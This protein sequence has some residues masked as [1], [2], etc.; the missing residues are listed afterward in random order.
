METNQAK[1]FLCESNAKGVSVKITVKGS[2]KIITL[3]EVYV[4]GTGMVKVKITLQLIGVNNAFNQR[5]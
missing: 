5:R 1:T 3:C 4:Y 2:H